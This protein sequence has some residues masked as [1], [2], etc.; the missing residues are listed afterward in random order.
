MAALY[1]VAAAA[2][3]VTGEGLRQALREKLGKREEEIMGTIAQE[4]LREGREEGLTDG[5][6]LGALEALRVA[7]VRLV[8]LK[9]DAA[10]ADSLA[11]RL[12]PVSDLQ[13]LEALLEAIASAPNQ[14]GVRAAINSALD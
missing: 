14:D 3:Q 8:R 2:P 4:W 11:S 5:R 12:E 7:C 6:R 1:Y 9:L 13:I 10:E